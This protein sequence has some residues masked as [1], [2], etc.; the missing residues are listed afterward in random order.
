[1]VIQWPSRLLNDY[2]SVFGIGRILGRGGL[3]LATKCSNIYFNV[4]HSIKLRNIYK[5]LN[6]I[7]FCIL[8]QN[9]ERKKVYMIKAIFAHQK[10]QNRPLLCFLHIL[11]TVMYLIQNWSLLKLW[12][13]NTIIPGSLW[14]KLS[15]CSCHHNWNIFKT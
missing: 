1:M 7:L 12:K 3:A 11:I 2:L 6:E 13:S 9:F 10:S 15:W 5:P 8:Q 14:K 4:K